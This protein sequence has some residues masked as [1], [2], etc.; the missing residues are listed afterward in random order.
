M[1]T[2]SACSSVRPGESSQLQPRSDSHQLKGAPNLTVRDSY[3]EAF[4]E[5]YDRVRQGFPPPVRGGI[6]KPIEPNDPQVEGWR[7]GARAAALFEL[8]KP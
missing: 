6:G 7:D 3:W 5:S 8:R 2:L 4:L 1:V